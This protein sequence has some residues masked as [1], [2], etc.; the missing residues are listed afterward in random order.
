M[1]ANPLAS[2]NWVIE[3]GMIRTQAGRDRFRTDLRTVAEYSDFELR[4]EWKISERGNAGVK[5]NVHEEWISDR[6]RPDMSQRQKAGMKRGAVG[7]EYQLSD[8]SLWDRSHDDWAKSAISALISSNGPMR[9][10][11]NRA[12][13]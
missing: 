8:D 13:N 5:Y 2:Q 4:F 7:F 12:A 10:L 1:R 11:S 9:N 6:F 3:G